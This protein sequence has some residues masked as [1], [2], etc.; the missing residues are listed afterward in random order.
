MAK[1]TSQGMQ[2]KPKGNSQGTK[3]E[4]KRNTKGGLRISEGIPKKTCKQIQKVVKVAVNSK[5]GK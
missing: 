3:R 5:I 1:V 2:R 4:F